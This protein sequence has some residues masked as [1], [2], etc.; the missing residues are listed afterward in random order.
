MISDSMQVALGFGAT[1]MQVTMSC[2]IGTGPVTFLIKTALSI[3]Q[4][5]GQCYNHLFS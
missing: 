3:W 4:I 5:V 1:C 2:E